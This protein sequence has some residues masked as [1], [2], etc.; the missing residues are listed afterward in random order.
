M[1]TTPERNDNIFVRM[2]N[3]KYFMS[4]IKEARRVKYIV[5]GRPKDFYTVTDNETNDTVLQGMF[6]GSVWLTT[7]SKTYWQEPTI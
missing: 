4:L 3:H 7:F 6:N 2:C 5:E 1:A